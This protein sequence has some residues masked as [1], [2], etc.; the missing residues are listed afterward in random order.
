MPF[1]RSATFWRS[2]YDDALEP[3]IHGNT[4]ELVIGSQLGPVAGFVRSALGR[5]RS[6]RFGQDRGSHRHL[7]PAHWPRAQ[8]RVEPSSPTLGLVRPGIDAG[9][10]RVRDGEDLNLALPHGP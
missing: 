2:A 1:S 3:T 5:A 7:R 6:L 8:H 9:C 4:V 10:L